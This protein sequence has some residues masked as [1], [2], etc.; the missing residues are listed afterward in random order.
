MCGVQAGEQGV[1]LQD[2]ATVQQ[3]LQLS[4]LLDEAFAA[5]MLCM[6]NYA[7]AATTIGAMISLHAAFPSMLCGLQPSIHLLAGAEHS[8]QLELARA[9]NGH[10]PSMTPPSACRE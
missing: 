10:L 6:A 8:P 4:A 2:A 5:L 9:H 7:H 1:A 3:L